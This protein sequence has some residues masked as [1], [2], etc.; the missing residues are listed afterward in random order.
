MRIVS[1][2]YY[3]SGSSQVGLGRGGGCE[4]LLRGAMNNFPISYLEY[5]IYYVF[6]Y[7]TRICK[8]TVPVMVGKGLPRYGPWTILSPNNKETPNPNMK[9]SNSTAYFSPCNDSVFSK[10]QF[11]PKVDLLIMS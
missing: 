11:T 8:S 6:T 4:R 5:W 7:S 9:S 1:P 2:T 10:I 3:V